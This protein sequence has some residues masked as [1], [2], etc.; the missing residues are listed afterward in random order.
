MEVVGDIVGEIYDLLPF[1]SDSSLLQ[2]M[3]TL[4]L[5]LPQDRVVPHW[6]S[7][8][9]SRCSRKQPT[10]WKIEANKGR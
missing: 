5:E 10:Q 1:P 4:P 3:K 7:S 9:N 2:F 6:R 8:R